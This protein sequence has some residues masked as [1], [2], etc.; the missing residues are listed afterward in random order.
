MNTII[1]E[2][3]IEAIQMKVHSDVSIQMTLG[4]GTKVPQITYLIEP[5]QRAHRD[6]Q[7]GYLDHPIRSP[8]GKVMPPGKSPTRPC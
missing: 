1:G 6:D 3:T 5:C 4:H 8:D 7:N 2:A